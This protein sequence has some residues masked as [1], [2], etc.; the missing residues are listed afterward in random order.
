MVIVKFAGYE[1][2][3]SRGK[4]SSNG[5]TSLTLVDIHDGDIIAT[6]SVN[7]ESYPKLEEGEVIIKDYSENSGMFIA[8]KEAGII[9]PIKGII[10]SG[11]V[12]LFVC[13][14]YEE[15]EWENVEK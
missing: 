11:W 1:C 10:T 13:D 8:L 9:G 2:K 4:Y 14:L 15:I 6:A 5:R 7:V 3:V 12:E